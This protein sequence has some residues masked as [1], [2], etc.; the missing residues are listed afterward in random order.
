MILQSINP[1]L[2]EVIG[3][4]NEHQWEEVNIALKNA[5]DAQLQW[6]E[7]DIHERAASLMRMAAELRQRKEELAIIITSEMGKVITESLAEV[8]KCALVCEYYAQQGASFL[9]NKYIETD[10]SQSYVTYQPLGIVLAI[11]PWNFPFWQVFRCAAPAIMAGN[12]VVLK[13]ASNVS[14]CALAIEEVINSADIPQGLFKTLLLSSKKVEKLISD[15]RIKAISLTGSTATGKEV[16]LQAAQ[17]FKKC[18]LELGGS[19]P[20]IVL[21]DADIEQAVDACVKGRIINAGQSC[22]AAK[23]FIVEEAIYPQ[24][25]ELFVDKINSYVMGDP[26]DSASQYG[27]LARFNLREDMMRQVANSISKGAH[28]LTGGILPEM[29]GAYYPATVLSNVMP[30][31]PA[32]SEEIFGPVASIIK[33]KDINEAIKLANDTTFGLGAAI[34]TG[35]VERARTIAEKKLEAGCC[36]INDYVRSDPRLPF[37][38]TKDSGMG[39]ELSLYGLLEFVNIKTIYVR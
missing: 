18:V 4:Y 9:T 12:G 15:K 34:F 25:E 19:D 27:P 7:I 36:F 21:A 22:I 24:F 20:Y 38:G 6:T 2:D 16:A 1:A 29:T 39:R 11:M 28:L 5:V 33:A 13:H 31:M 35:D 37:G 14:G 3:Q 8:E 17:Y 30:G 10:A 26:L 23:R 32:Y